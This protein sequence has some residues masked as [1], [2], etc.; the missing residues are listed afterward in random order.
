THAG[1]VMDAHQVIPTAKIAHLAPFLARLD[2]LAA[3]HQSLAPA[4]GGTVLE[5]TG[6]LVGS[7]PRVLL[8]CTQIQLVIERERRHRPGAGQPVGVVLEADRVP[9][10]A[11]RLRQTADQFRATERFV[12]DPDIQKVHGL[13]FRADGGVRGRALVRRSALSCSSRP[14]ASWA[15]SKSIS[16]A[17]PS[18]VSARNTVARLVEGSPFSSLAR[19]GT[20]TPTLSAITSWVMDRRIRA[21]RSRRPNAW[22]WRCTR[23][24]VGGVRLAIPN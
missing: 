5:S 1:F 7:G 12:L 13:R 17:R 15:A 8:A 18:T 11:G 10:P 6:Q 21:A 2:R 22:I 20:L 14:R 9:G 4:V 23:G 3:I 16:P 19:V 24:W